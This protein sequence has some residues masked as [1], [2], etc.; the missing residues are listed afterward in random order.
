MG[1]FSLGIG[2]PSQANHELRP[3]RWAPPRVLQRAYALEEK[4]K[5]E[6]LIRRFRVTRQQS[7][8]VALYLAETLRDDLK[9]GI[10]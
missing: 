7:W 9:G 3:A 4:P 8:Q 1:W 5:H 2:L 6:K 10:V